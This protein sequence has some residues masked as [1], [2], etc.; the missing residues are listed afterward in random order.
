MPIQRL[1][2]FV[3]AVIVNVLL[4]VLIWLGGARLPGFSAGPGS[5]PTYGADTVKA[6]VL[7]IL[8]TGEID[9]GGVLQTYQVVR[10][11]V[12]EGPFIETTFEM[13]YGRRQVR[14]PGRG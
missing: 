14:P 8:E 6:R 1:K 7:A 3:P 5:N 13:D 2:P 9:L 4:L 10:I 11:Q 12:T